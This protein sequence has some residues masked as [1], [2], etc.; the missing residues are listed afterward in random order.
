V[1]VS[2][3]VE[4]VLDLLGGEAERR[5][6]ALD[7]EVPPQLLVAGDSER[8]R[9]V[10]MNLA[11]N[12]LEATPSGGRVRV[13]AHGGPD[14]VVIVV[15]DSGTGIS[16]EAHDRIFEPFFT[17]KATGSGLGLPLVH[18]IVTQHGGLIDVD[19]SPLGGARFSVR[20]PRLRPA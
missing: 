9:Q 20:L 5:Q 16:P 12:A 19:R 7:R 10:F 4:A 15:E 1:N 8:L 17:T 3:P 18:A 14:E 2:E 13:L 11:L 6:V